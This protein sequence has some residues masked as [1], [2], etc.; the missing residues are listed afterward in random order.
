MA[1]HT[2]DTMVAPMILALSTSLSLSA[3]D[4]LVGA[5]IPAAALLVVLGLHLV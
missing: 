1:L 3:T 5:A 4:L 2:S